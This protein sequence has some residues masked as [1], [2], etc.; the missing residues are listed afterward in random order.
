[1][2]RIHC[3]LQRLPASDQ[4]HLRPRPP[5]RLRVGGQD[6]RRRPDPGMRK[7]TAAAG[8]AGIQEPRA[9][10]A[11][12]HPRRGASG[13]DRARETLELETSGRARA[14]AHAGV[15]ELHDLPVPHPEQPALGR[16]R[17]SHR[18]NTR[19]RAGRRRTS[20]R[21]PKAPPRVPNRLRSRSRRPWRSRLPGPLWKPSRRK[22]FGPTPSPR[23]KVI[24]FF[25][26]NSN[27][28]TRE[29]TSALDQIATYLKSER[30]LTVAIRGY[31]DAVGSAT[32]NLSVA[33]FRANS[34]KSYL[35]GKGVNPNNLQVIGLGAKDPIAS[36]DTPEGRQQNRRVEIEPLR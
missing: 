33:Q 34:I 1:M 35:A 18:R 19:A 12:S 2:R 22:R 27:E 8:N 5:D 11:R 9:A 16:W 23:G 15:H 29:V 6:D 17:T 25:P 32:Y 26:H 30:N 4:H 31:T 24:L 14:P 10:R 21:R 7:G 13:R 20:P 3:L 28:L 36:N